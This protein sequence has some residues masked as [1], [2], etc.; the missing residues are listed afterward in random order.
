MLGVR[1]A[2]AKLPA[3]SPRADNA[4]QI[5]LELSFEVALADGSLASV[6]LGTSRLESVRD[7][8]DVRHD[9]GIV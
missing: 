9:I 7:L 4:A 5:D 8:S 6:Q 2:Q 1:L 3:H